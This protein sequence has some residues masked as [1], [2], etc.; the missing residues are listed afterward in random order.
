VG[1]K[2]EKAMFKILKESGNLSSEM[3]CELLAT[4]GQYLGHSS[5]MHHM[6]LKCHHSE[7]ICK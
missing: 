4:F 3:L 6:R 2:K 1:G 7:I 5:N